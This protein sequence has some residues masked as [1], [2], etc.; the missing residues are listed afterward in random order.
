MKTIVITGIQSKTNTSYIVIY[1]VTIDTFE[2][3]SFKTDVNEQKR[4]S[5]LMATATPVQINL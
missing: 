2:K 4:L 1:G 5:S 3:V